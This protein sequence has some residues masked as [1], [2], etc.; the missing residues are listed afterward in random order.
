MRRPVLEGMPDAGPQAGTPTACVSQ[1]APYSCSGLKLVC[2]TG[3][4]H[5][6]V[7]LA[8]RPHLAERAPTGQAGGTPAGRQGGIAGRRAKGPE[9]RAPGER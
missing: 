5:V 8:W 9:R 3:A 2:G 4:G 1:K 7:R 6:L